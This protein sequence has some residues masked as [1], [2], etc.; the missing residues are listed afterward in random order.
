MVEAGSRAPGERLQDA[1][2][3]PP[4]HNTVSVTREP[5]TSV[6]T[7]GTTCSG[8]LGQQH[9]KGTG[10]TLSSLPAL[11]PQRRGPRRHVWAVTRPPS[12]DPQ[13]WGAHVARPRAAHHK[14][15]CDGEASV[16]CN[17]VHQNPRVCWGK[18]RASRGTA[19]PPCCASSCV[20]GGAAAAC[21]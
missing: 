15:T 11:S 21:A 16:R 5:S 20:T 10:E 1:T 9:A 12:Q 14:G 7:V 8:G 2:L 4:K 17:L 18:A 19:A 13:P 3:L 6:H